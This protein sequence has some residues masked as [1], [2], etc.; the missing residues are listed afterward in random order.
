MWIR[1]YK[2]LFFI[3]SII[4]SLSSCDSGY[5]FEKGEWVWVSYDEAV[6]RRVTNVDSADIETFKV[7]NEKNYAIDKNSVFLESEKINH[8]DPRTFEVLRNGYSKDKNRVYLDYE[9]VLFANP[10]TFQILDFPYSKDKND[11]YCGTIPLKLSKKEINEFT[12]TNTDSLLADTK[13]TVVLSYFIESN[14]D[15]A[16]VDTLDIKSV[17][18]GEWATGETKSRKFKGFREINYN[19]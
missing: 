12:V 5:R 13:S 14:P 19:K 9:I 16:W 8:A 17:I 6:G 11:V 10:N 4:L 1:T 2:R 3:L 15:Y 7:L 18:I